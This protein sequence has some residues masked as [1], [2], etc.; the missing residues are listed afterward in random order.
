MTLVD[1]TVADPRRI[2]NPPMLHDSVRHGYSHVVSAPASPLVFVSGQYGSDLAGEVVPGGFV[3]QVERTVDNLWMALASEG[4]G[5]GNVVRLGSYV[6]DHDG[7]KLAAWTAVL[8]GIWG[9]RPP[10]QTLCPVP[11][12]ALPDMLFELDAIAVRP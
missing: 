4:L 2:T 3:A 7:D 12:L 6:V 1:P 9:G 11:R 8:R 10:A 5:F